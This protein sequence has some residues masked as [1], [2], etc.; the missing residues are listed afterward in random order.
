[1]VIRIVATCAVMIATAVSAMADEIAGSG[2][3]SGKWSGGAYTDQGAFSHC[4][5]ATDYQSGIRLHFAIDKT[6]HWRLGMS[7]PEWAMTPGESIPITYEVDRSGANA[8]DARVISKDFLLAELVATDRVFNQF[9]RGKMLR[10]DAGS[11]SYSFVLTG[12]SRALSRTLKC[13]ER[14]INYRDQPAPGAPGVPSASMSLDGAMPTAIPTHAPE[15]TR[16]EASSGPQ[17]PTYAGDPSANRTVEG[18]MPTLIPAFAPEATRADANSDPQAPTTAAVSTSADSSNR[19]GDLPQTA[20]L[21]LPGGGADGQRATTASA[22]PVLLDT[23]EPTLDA[24]RFMF[25]VFRSDA[26][27]QYRFTDHTAS[28]SD[29]SEI[30]RSA[31]IAWTSPSGDGALRVY[32]PGSAQLDGVIAEA[33][34]EDARKCRGAFA[35]GKKPAEEDPA[36]STAFTACKDGDVYE[37]YRD[38]VA[39]RHGSG[40]LYLIASDQ[41]GTSAIDET[42]PNA[43]VHSIAALAE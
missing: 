23:P 26:F 9:R 39:F 1:M 4:A 33:I 13:V 14:N 40:N 10:I 16:R 2:F 38:Y 17:A 3:S 18:A 36:I 32:D 41:S 24:V 31:A 34:A 37:T 8:S 43:F 42:V 15:A 29:G 11:Q 27:A 7:H 28:G 25:R 20:A 6:Y 19:Q 35:S 21:D 22:G 30:D 5:M 12:T